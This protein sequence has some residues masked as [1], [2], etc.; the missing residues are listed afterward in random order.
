MQS[1]LIV[2]A[3]IALVYLMVTTAVTYL[4]LL[5]AR[6]TVTLPEEAVADEVKEEAAPCGF[7]ILDVDSPSEGSDSDCDS[8][9]GAAVSGEVLLRCSTRRSGRN[10]VLV[11]PSGQPLLAPLSPC[12][13]VTTTI[14]TQTE[15]DV[16]DTES[17]S[18]PSTRGLP[19]STPISPQGEAIADLASFH[20][21]MGSEMAELMRGIDDDLLEMSAL[22][23]L[24]QRVYEED[25]ASPLLTPLEKVLPFGRM[26]TLCDDSD[27]EFVLIEN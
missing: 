13:S 3:F 20:D 25:V 17:I 26:T 23:P 12:V 5:W 19:G 18:A 8:E 10:L 11:V 2:S 9:I 7:P 4:R 16:S 22:S 27:D 1:V 21:R 15:G 6:L 14:A 24:P